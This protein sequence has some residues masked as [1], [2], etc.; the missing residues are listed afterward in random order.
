MSNLT[1]FVH[2][3]PVCLLFSLLGNHLKSFTLFFKTS[4]TAICFSSHQSKE[5]LNFARKKPTNQNF[6]CNISMENP[7]QG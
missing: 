5:Y 1:C 2:I 3:A 4:R 7:W 6:P